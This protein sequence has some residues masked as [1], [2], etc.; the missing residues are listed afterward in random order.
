MVDKYLFVGDSREVFRARDTQGVRSGSKLT[1]PKGTFDA[2]GQGN[3]GN[4]YFASGGTGISWFQESVDKIA[5][6][7]KAQKSDYIVVSMG[8]N[9]WPAFTT[10]ANANRFVK[11]YIDAAK[12]IEEKTGKKV[13]FVS[14]YP[15]NGAYETNKWNK[16]IAHDQKH[17]NQ[18]LGYFNKALAK[19]TK[20][21]GMSYIDGFS[22][23]QK[24]LGQSKYWNDSVHGSKNLSQ[25]LGDFIQKELAKQSSVERQVTGYQMKSDVKGAEFDTHVEVRELK[26]PPIDE[27]EKEPTVAHAK[28]TEIV[29]G[30]VNKLTKTQKASMKKWAGRIK[31]SEESLRKLQEKYGEYSYNIMLRAMMEPKNIMLDAGKERPRVSS[32]IA[33][34]YMISNEFTDAQMKKILSGKYGTKYDKVASRT[35]TPTLTADKTQKKESAGVVKK[36]VQPVT[37]HTTATGKTVKPSSEIKGTKESRYKNVRE[38]A[39]AYLMQWENMRLDAYKDGVDRT[40][41]KQKYSIGLGT[42]QHKEKGVMVPTKSNDHITPEQAVQYCRDNVD[43][44]W[45]VLKKSGVKVEKMTEQEMMAVLSYMYNRGPGNIANKEHKN[46]VAAINAYLEDRN[47]V[48]KRNKVREVLLEGVD[49]SHKKR[50]E[51]EIAMLLGDISEKDWNKVP[52]P[53]LN[54]VAYSYDKRTGH[55][56][57]GLDRAID[58]C[59]GDSA[60][61]CM[62][63]PKDVRVAQVKKSAQRGR[64]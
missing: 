54:T 45:D 43:W 50:R 64:A 44:C 63:H 48:A 27:L 14:P 40:T 15:V 52:F 58:V 11:K 23:G 41:G 49:A 62:Y 55:Y 16:Y 30:D 39:P 59:R 35:E 34:E 24:Y 47:N 2:L 10:Q 56:M 57:A 17:L 46:R 13:V 61:W 38:W 42:Q 3:D 1:N 51:S 60:L 33:V 28:N 25:D 37:S 6:S 22:Y 31:L 36:Q 19:A 7:A 18:Y 5:A 4:Y 32:R 9:D 26:T 12:K 8:V 21:A 29:Y 53:A 20:D